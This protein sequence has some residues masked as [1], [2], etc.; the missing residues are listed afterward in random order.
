MEKLEHPLWIVDF[1]NAILGP[2]VRAIG[3]ALGYHFTGH[4]VIPNY[5]VMVLL[6]V[7]GLT[8]LSLIVRSRLSVENPGKL[9]IVLEDGVRAVVGLLEEW[10]GPKGGQFLPLIA[11]LGAFILVGFSYWTLKRGVTMLAVLVAKTPDAG[12]KTRG[13]AARELWKL[14]LRYALL[15]LLAYV[16]IARLRLHPWGLLAGASSVVAGVSLEAFRLAVKR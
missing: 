3:E 10:I 11:T 13:N 1:V 6:I 8:V 15:A 14:V 9:Q 16:M 7:T 5:L 12:L 2:P 4:H